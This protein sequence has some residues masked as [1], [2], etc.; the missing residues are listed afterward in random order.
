M[1]KRITAL[2]LVLILC[3]GL[4]TGCGEQTDDGTQ[5][6]T[7]TTGD[8]VTGVTIDAAAAYAKNDP[9]AVV[10]TVNGSEVPWDEL[11]YRL[12]SVVYQLEYYGGGSVVW[13]DPCIFNSAYTNG[14]YAWL[15]AV[16]GCI[17]YHMLEKHFDEM[18]ITLDAEDEATLAEILAKDMV[19]MC[20]E[21]ATEED[22]NAALGDLYL[23]RETYDF[24]NKMG[25]LYEN[26][27]E[28]VCGMNGENL[29]EADI[30]ACIEDNQYRTVKHILLMTTDAEGNPLPE[31]E[32]AVKR[33]I[34]EQVLSDLQAVSGDTDA[35]LKLFD[36]KMHEYSEDTGLPYYPDGYTFGPGKMVEEFEA[37]SDELKDYEMSGIVESTF[38]YH[39]LLRLPTTRDSVVEYVDGTNDYTIGT[40][41]AASIFGSMMNAWTEEAEVKWEPAFETLTAEMVF[42]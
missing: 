28:K 42:A 31:D 22:F 29:E 39:I 3:L 21:N 41:A 16:D 23:T 13:N 12:Y 36:E 8:T 35:L 18:N 5:D 15:V 37:A 10:M 1:K 11:F 38:G 4:L 24:M 27:Y 32:I 7:T 20:G 9:A 17:Q 19:G 2:L 6:D 34:A 40:Y 30:Q 25:V 14:E 26:A 33:D